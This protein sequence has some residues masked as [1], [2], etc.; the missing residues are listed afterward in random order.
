LPAPSAQDSLRLPSSAAVEAT[1]N[2]AMP[3]AVSVAKPTTAVI[4]ISTW[5][6]VA[7]T[8]VAI[9]RSVV[10]EPASVIAVS[11]ITVK[12]WAGADEHTAYEP[13]RPVVAIRRARVR[14]ICVVSIGADWGWSGVAIAGADSNANSYLCLRISGWQHENAQQS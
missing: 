8:V 2:W 13:L 12:P 1:A 6:V 9:A 5:S 7:A 14:I 10:T 3:I 4:C 11:V